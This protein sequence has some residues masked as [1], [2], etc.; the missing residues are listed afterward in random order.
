[1]N[2]DAMDTMTEDNSIKID[3]AK[4]IIRID[5]VYVKV[6]NDEIGITEFAQQV[7]REALRGDTK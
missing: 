5:D 2:H 1:M 6:G 4:L 3:H 7:I